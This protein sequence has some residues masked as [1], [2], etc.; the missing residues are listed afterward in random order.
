MA[1]IVLSIT[2]FQ[3]MALNSY[4]EEKKP[5]LLNEKLTGIIFI[6]DSAKM[7]KQIEYLLK[8]AQ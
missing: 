1:I 7:D 4:L 3:E 8:I 2:L 6:S 5:D